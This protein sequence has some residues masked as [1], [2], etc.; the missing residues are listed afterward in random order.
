MSAVVVS[1]AEEPLV[2]VLM[3]TFGAGEWVR[4]SLSALVERTPAVYELVV[5]DNASTDGTGDWLAANAQGATLLRNQANVGFG[6][7]VNQAA[8]HSRGRYLCLLNSDALVEEGWLEPMLADL[9][10]VAHCGAVVPRLLNLDGT[11]QEA[12]AVI[13]SDGQTMAIGYGDDPSRPWYR[14]PRYVSYGSGA[15]LCLRRSTFLALGGFDPAYGKG[16][17]E[18]V[19]LCLRMAAEGFRTVYEP[20][21]IVRHVRGASSASAEV[22]C[23]LEENARRFRTR[24]A[25]SL[26]ELPTLAELPSH[27]YRVLATRDALAPDRLLVVGA[28]LPRTHQDRIGRLAARIM[29]VAGEARVTVIGLEDPEPAEEAAWLADL[30]VE[31]VWGVSDWED[32]MSRARNHYS[33]VVLADPAVAEWLMEL[34]GCFQP[35]ADLVALEGADGWGDL[36]DE[37][38]AL[39][40]SNV[41]IVPNGPAG[42]GAVWPGSRLDWR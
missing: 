12:G 27:P 31:L 36:D 5:L 28:R 25:T 13:G 16:Y 18:D 21:S 1:R 3:V 35:Q 34:V 39:A 17:Y 14:F 23:L 38:L 11:L 6:P 15:C 29:A 4:R 32:W 37:E 9:E 2:S 30:G 41:G 40:L 19:D 22:N 7:G 33:V 8:L 24:W 26:A 10:S 42:W 20:R